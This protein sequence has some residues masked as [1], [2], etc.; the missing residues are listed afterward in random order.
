MRND[1][2]PLLIHML[3]EAMA[4]GQQALLTVTSHS[5]APLL[6]AGD[7][8]LLTAVS[9]AQLHHG[10][11][12]TFISQ[13]QLLTHRFYNI[14]TQDNIVYL[15]TRGDR[16]AMFDALVPTT[17]LVGRVVAYQRNGRQLLLTKGLSQWLMQPIHFLAQREAQWLMHNQTTK[18]GRRFVWLGQTLFAVIAHKCT[19]T[20]IKTPTPRLLT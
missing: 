15:Q 11:V 8:V 14:V 16:V 12:I 18:V 9:P 4:Q 3:R 6:Q 1:D 17:D 7:Q 5:M 20:K 19:A 2:L 10:D 13:S